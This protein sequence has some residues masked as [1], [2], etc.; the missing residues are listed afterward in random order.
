[1]PRTKSKYPDECRKI[2]DRFI[3]VLEK[4]LGLSLAEAAAELGYSNPSTL[5]AIR[6]GKALPSHEKI[7]AAAEILK[8]RRNRVIDMNWLFTGVKKPYI[9][10]ISTDKLDAIDNDIINSLQHMSADQ[11]KALSVLLGN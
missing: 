4:K 11:K 7:L 3:Y 10:A 8:S 6:D 2:G 9:T 5:Y 1:M